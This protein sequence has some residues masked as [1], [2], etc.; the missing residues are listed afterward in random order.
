MITQIQYRI[1]CSCAVVKISNENKP[2]QVNISD[3]SGSN[4]ISTL[5]AFNY[6]ISLRVEW[7][8]DTFNW[9]WIEGYSICLNGI[10][11]G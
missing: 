9:S 4:P 8:V 11:I 10:F 1:L 5:G 3:E 6:S 7:A 2:S